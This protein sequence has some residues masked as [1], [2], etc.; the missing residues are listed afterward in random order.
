MVN[1]NTRFNPIIFIDII[2]KNGF[3]FILHVGGMCMHDL[4]L[5]QFVDK[6]K[7]LDYKTKFVGP[8]NIPGEILQIEISS[9]QKDALKGNY[10]FY[11]LIV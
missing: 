6:D 11:I 3:L 4:L 1:T 8:D 7:K 2:L 5:S 9:T 10:L